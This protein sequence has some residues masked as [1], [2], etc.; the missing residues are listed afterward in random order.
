MR[1]PPR[2]SRA[3]SREHPP[4]GGCACD[5]GEGQLEASLRIELRTVHE[6]PL[7]CLDHLLREVR[8]S[9]L[10][11]RRRASPV[12]RDQQVIVPQKTGVTPEHRLDDAEPTT[13]FR[14]VAPFEGDPR[15]AKLDCRLQCLTPFSVSVTVYQKEQ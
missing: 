2:P 8:R 10:E 1:R 6:G 3:S 12:I 5:E 4:R 7:I 9:G 15:L 14:Q 13:R 11:R